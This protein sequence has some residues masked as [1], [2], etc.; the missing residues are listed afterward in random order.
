MNAIKTEQLCEEL[1]KLGY[2]VLPNLLD[3]KLCDKLN[4]YIKTHISSDKLK[5]LANINNPEHRL[6]FSLPLD[7]VVKTALIS[8]SKLLS[9][10]LIE[11]LGSN[12]VLVEL[13]ALVAK[14]GA[15][16]Q[17]CHPDSENSANP[18]EAELLSIFIPVDDVD[19]SMGPIEIWPGS[20]KLLHSE[21]TIN[22]LK[23]K[24]GDC[25]TTQKGH[26]IVM[27]SK[28]WHRGSDNFS[29]KSRIVFYFSYISKKGMEPIGPTWTIKKELANKHS[30]ESICNQNSIGKL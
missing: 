15:E 3:Y 17:S 23:K 21:K 30:L 1:S 13:G 11:T 10:F 6:N 24:K 8:A 22:Y 27:N 29:N 28:T 4:V 18:F 2:V 9:P 12:A 19:R 26:V 14:P 25:L 20:H 16:R 7:H 5:L